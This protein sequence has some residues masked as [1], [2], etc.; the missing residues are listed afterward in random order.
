MK[1]L[2]LAFQIVLVVLM[3]DLI[4]IR[5]QKPQGAN[6]AVLVA[7]SSG[8]FNYRHQ[9]DISHAYNIVKQQ[10]IPESNIITFMFDDIAY[11][12][13]NPFPGQLFNQ[14]NG[15]NVY[16]GRQAIDY[17]EVDV[18]PENFLKVLMGQNMDGI[19]SGKTL[20]SGKNDKVFIYFSVSIE[21]HEH[22]LNM[23]RIM[24]HP[25]CW[26]SLALRFVILK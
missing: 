1:Q 5:A 11:N 3:V 18:T 8:Y 26:H 12:K 10:G 9:A 25:T 24:E 2:R 20:K 13:E 15:S 14:Y 6:W 16:P 4:F 17:R 23:N 19:G 22:W 21:S 7:G